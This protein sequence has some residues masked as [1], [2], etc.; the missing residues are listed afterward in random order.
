[1]GE[2][3]LL[4]RGNRVGFHVDVC[5]RLGDDIMTGFSVES[6]RERE[7]ECLDE[8]WTRIDR[9]RKVYIHSGHIPAHPLIWVSWTWTRSNRFEEG[10]GL[11]ERNVGRG[12][13]RHGVTPGKAGRVRN[14]EMLQETWELGQ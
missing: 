6:R 4:R 1:V 3:L 9:G 7:R 12:D 5:Q 8:Q 11:I 13:S 10:A 14:G 2:F